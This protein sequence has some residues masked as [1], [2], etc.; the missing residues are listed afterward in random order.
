VT[1]DFNKFVNQNIDDPLCPTCGH[2][3]DWTLH[4]KSAVC[5]KG[6][7]PFSGHYISYV[8]VKKQDKDL[9]KGKSAEDDNNYYWL[10]LDDMNSSNRVTQIY[11]NN[12]S[13][14]YTDLAE[15]A[16]IVFYELDKTCHHGRGSLT[17]SYSTDNV[18]EIDGEE[19]EGR[20]SKKIELKVDVKTIGS[21]ETGPEQDCQCDDSHK[22]SH[23]KRNHHDHQHHRYHLKD[24]C[25]LM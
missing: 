24:S 12:S 2:L 16:Y 25:R 7:S 9:E 4:F 5:H 15:N 17:L 20:D 23:K 1:I 18:S 21:Q 8:R 3:I 19:E 11:N 13:S 14:V 22:K 6:D 10:K